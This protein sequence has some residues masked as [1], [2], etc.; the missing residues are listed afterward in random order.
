MESLLARFAFLHAV[1][2]LQRQKKYQSQRYP[3]TLHNLVHYH[4]SQLWT[5]TQLEIGC[6]WSHS[7]DSPQHLFSVSLHLPKQGHLVRL[8]VLLHPHLFQVLSTPEQFWRH[9]LVFFAC[10]LECSIIVFDMIHERQ[11]RVE[12]KSQM[13]CTQTPGPHLDAQP[14]VEQFYFNFRVQICQLAQWSCALI[15]ILITKQH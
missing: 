6:V 14:E 5:Q 10:S 2:L 15:D 11:L 7:P 8:L 4:T 3:K 12:N 9:L 13:H 1:W